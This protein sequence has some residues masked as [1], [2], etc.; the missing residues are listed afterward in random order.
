MPNS[1]GEAHVVVD[2]SDTREILVVSSEDEAME[3]FEGHTEEEDDPEEDQDIDEAVME[4]QWN[5]EIDEMVV[6]QQV[7]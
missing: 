2:L 4:Q 3:G 1:P 5:Q 6:E 7:E